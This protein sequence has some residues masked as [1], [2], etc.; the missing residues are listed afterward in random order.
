MY[1]IKIQ[2]LCILQNSHH[3]SLV[4]RHHVWSQ[5]FLLVLS[6]SKV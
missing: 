5:S 2:Y 3:N 6:T 1:N 4:N